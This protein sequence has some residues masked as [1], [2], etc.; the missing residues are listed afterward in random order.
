MPFNLTENK[1][2]LSGSFGIEEVSECW[3]L[4][5]GRGI[6]NF[7]ELDLSGLEKIDLAGWQ[8]VLM[9]LRECPGIEVLKPLAPA[10]ELELLVAALSIKRGA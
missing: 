4:I 9:L 10:Q 1:V 6:E 3:D 5:K 2:T 8:I 7:A